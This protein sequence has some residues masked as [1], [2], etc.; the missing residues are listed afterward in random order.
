M[1]GASVQAYLAASQKVRDEILGIQ[2]GFISWQV[3]K[4]GDTWA[5]LI[6]WETPEDAKNAETAGQ[7]NPNAQE[8]YSYMDFSSMKNQMFTVEKS[9]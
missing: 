5:D 4:D 7:G 3:L 6:I 8:Y 1:E 9:Y 2:K